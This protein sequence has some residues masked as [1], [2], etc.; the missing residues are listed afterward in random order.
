TICAPR[1]HTLQRWRYTQLPPRKFSVDGTSIL[2]DKPTGTG[3]GSRACR[4]RPRLFRHQSRALLRAVAPTLA[5]LPY[6]LRTPHH[7]ADGRSE[8]DTAGGGA[9]GRAALSAV[10]R[11]KTGRTERPRPAKRQ[12]SDELSGG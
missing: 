1:R 7:S 2:P 8:R 9:D 10:L 4:G 6:R 11:R 3:R 5:A 12:R